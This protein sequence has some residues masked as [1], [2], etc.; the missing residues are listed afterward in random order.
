MNRTNISGTNW[1]RRI[2]GCYESRDLRYKDHKMRTRE[3]IPE[4][5][6][7]EGRETW[8]RSC[9]FGWCLE[10][11]CTSTLRD[12]SLERRENTENLIQF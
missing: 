4:G 2:S 8:V 7:L 5:T 12:I 1:K 6:C 11:R 3:Y 10:D 9:E